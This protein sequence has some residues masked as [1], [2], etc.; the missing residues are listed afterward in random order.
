MPRASIHRPKVAPKGPL[1]VVRAA[2]QA[3]CGLRKGG[4]KPKE[5]RGKMHPHL[6]ASSAKPRP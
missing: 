6:A 4:M 1:W 2:K 3:L 5:K